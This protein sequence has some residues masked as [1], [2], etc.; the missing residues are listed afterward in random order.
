M[1]VA[2]EHA[3]GGLHYFAW[4]NAN[5]TTFGSEHHRYD[6]YIRSFTRGH[7]EGGIPTLS[8]DIRNPR[9]G[10]LSNGRKTWAWFARSVNGV[11]TPAFF[12]QLVGIPTDI[13]SD[14]ITL[15][16]VAKPLDYDDQKQ[17]AAEALKAPPGYDPIF[18]DPAHRDDPNALLEGR[19][20]RWHVDPISLKV[21]TSDILIGEDGEAVF[22]R[23]DV[24][25][26]SVSIRLVG[27]PLRSVTVDAKVSWTQAATGG[28]TL[29]DGVFLSYT[30]DGLI[31][32]WPKP[33]A[34]LGGGWTAAASSAT[35]VYGIGQALT[36]TWTVNYQNREKEHVNGDTLTVNLSVSAPQ[37]TGLGCILTER[38]QP[39]FFDPFADPQINVPASYA[40][41][42]ITVPPWQVAGLLT[43][44]YEASRERNERL[45]FTLTSDLQDILASDA[46]SEGDVSGDADEAEIVNVPGSDVGLPL[47][48]VLEWETVKL[49]PV[50]LGTIVTDNKTFQIAI[51]SGIAGSVLP[52]FSDT[53]GDTI[54]DGTVTWASL[55]T[56]L[57]SADV[58]DW[59]ANSTVPRGEVI[60][61]KP[62]AIY[63]YTTILPPTPA[64][65]AGFAVSLGL[66]VRP[67]DG[68]SYQ[69]ATG[70]GTT[71]LVEPTFNA[72][73]GATTVDGTVIWTSLGP[74]ISGIGLYQ[75][76]TGIGTT[77]LLRPAFPST[78]GATVV[79]GTAT[80]TCIG[81]AGAFI[82]VPIGDVSRS[83]YFPTD[84]GVRSVEYLLSV[85]RAHLLARARVVE[86]TFDCLIDRAIGLTCRNSARLFDQRL[87]GGQAVGKITSVTLKGDGPSGKFNATITIA[88]AI[89]RGGE[90][91]SDVGVPSIVEQGVI[92]PSIQVYIGALTVVS[93]NVANDIGYSRPVAAVV[94]DGLVFPLT[95]GQVIVSSVTHGSVAAQT[96]AILSAFVTESQIANLSTQAGN[97]VSSINNQRT[98]E[99][100]N[101]KNLSAQL[102]NN[103]IWNE[104]VLKPVV[105]GP[106]SAEYDLD[107][108]ALAVPKMIDLE[109]IAS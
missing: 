103:P 93:S 94:D 3:G 12:G 24:P 62:Q 75:V 35:D 63:P 55:G 40:N 30:G 2:P 23:S 9:V 86:I 29:I 49:Q 90:I 67:S 19:S 84:R 59:T 7:T 37:V 101:Q 68:K 47:I 17:A 91:A 100:L 53:V 36:A 64:P 41:T 98:V 42:S 45:R 31:S 107:V 108:T 27:K 6:E 43:A 81:S 102:K 22:L 48:D 5:E 46:S 70:I 15:V 76:C 88:C 85:A 61:L 58:P 28:L 92:D 80:W 109:A 89:G 10:L 82:G 99:Q 11:V 97:P 21:T 69:I 78:I 105:N 57:F 13:L 77:G 4:V 8:I 83:A 56:Q 25:Y 95:A 73:R 14:V 51:A 50:T 18:I 34:S 39:G 32:D 65:T 104:L 44:K 54:V 33:L 60:F 1:P 106:F 79:D 66:I 87:P 16:L 71:G 74:E 20:E 26:K 38:N 72:P 96:A 52:A